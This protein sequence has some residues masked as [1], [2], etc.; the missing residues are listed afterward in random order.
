MELLLYIKS[1]ANNSV[2]HIWPQP[3][4]NNVRYLLEGGTDPNIVD[5]DSNSL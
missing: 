4:I 2:K 5:K 1:M 3:N